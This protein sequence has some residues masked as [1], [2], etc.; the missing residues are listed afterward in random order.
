MAIINFPLKFLLFFAVCETNE[1]HLRNWTALRLIQENYT[2][3]VTAANQGF[4]A[5]DFSNAES[6]GVC[7]LLTFP[8]FNIGW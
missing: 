8:F 2:N 3:P 6:L 4:K 7:G 1:I 5:I